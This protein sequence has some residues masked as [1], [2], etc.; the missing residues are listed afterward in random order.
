MC[1]GR[2]WRTNAA[3]AAGL[4]EDLALE[5]APSEPWKVL[6]GVWPVTPEKEGD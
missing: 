1:G 5:A 4:L 3:Y 2:G 6:L